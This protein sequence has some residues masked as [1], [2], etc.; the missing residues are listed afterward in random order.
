MALL[1]QAALAPT[2]C[3]VAF[4][5]QARSRA[6]RGSPQRAQAVKQWATRIFCVPPVCRTYRAN[7]CGGAQRG[8]EWNG[9]LRSPQEWLRLSGV[10]SNPLSYR[11]ATK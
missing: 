1:L 2:K 9:G 8:M 11:L 3:P 6:A 7:A 4:A 10:C 5:L